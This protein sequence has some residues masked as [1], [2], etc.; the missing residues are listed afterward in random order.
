MVYTHTDIEK[1]LGY[2][3]WK[4][5]KKVDTLLKMDCKMYCHL[6]IDSTKQ[7]KLDVRKSS[8][9]IY[10]AI[11]TIN[12]NLGTLFLQQMDSNKA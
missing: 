5:K 4:S 11:K 6:G 8:R 7:E 2:K 12:T 9:K 1:V 10:Q 3:T